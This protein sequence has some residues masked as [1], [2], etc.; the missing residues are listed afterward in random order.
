MIIATYID[1][2]GTDLSVVNAARVSFGKK[3][4]WEGQEDGLYDGKG[5]RG[6]LAPRDKKLIAYLAKHKHTAATSTRACAATAAAVRL[7]MA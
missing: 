5:G 2:M 6:V 1:H 7:G 3:S 4:T